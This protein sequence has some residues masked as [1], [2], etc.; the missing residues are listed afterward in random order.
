MDLQPLKYSKRV[1]DPLHGAIFLSELEFKITT[2]PAFIRLANVKQLGLAANVYPGALYSR[3]VHSLGACHVAGQMLTALERNSGSN[4]ESRD[5]TVVK[6]AALMHDIGHYPFS[7]AT[8]EVVKDLVPS[9]LIL[10][11]GGPGKKSE[12]GY[13][14][15]HED[16][17]RFIIEQ[18][19]AI[20]DVLKKFKLTPKEIIT[21]LDGGDESNS[22][23][24]LVSSDLDCDRLDY[25]R[26][27][28]LNAGLPY[29]GV[30]AQYLIDNITLDS[31]NIPCLRERAIGSADH[32]LVSRLYDF[33]QLPFHKSVVGFEE[34]L[35]ITLRSMMGAGALD[36][37]RSGIKEQISKGKWRRFDDQF[38]M[39]RIRQFRDDVAE[40]NKKYEEV[41]PFID[42]ILNR[43]AP[44][45]VF[46]SEFVQQ[47]SEKNDF[48]FERY[49]DSIASIVEA[50]C[51]E[52]G[53]EKHLTFSWKRTFPILKGKESG[54]RIRILFGEGALDESFSI[55]R[56][57]RTLCAHLED[58]AR[59][60][61]RFYACLNGNDNP[62]RK[63]ADL[64]GKIRERCLQEGVKEYNPCPES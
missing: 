28:A 40:S 9:S 12:G 41:I 27:T 26:R 24:L 11:E 32:F 46:S 16:L 56:D 53:V 19:E 4:L 51:L 55:E 35:K 49:F 60:H 1:N 48:E 52:E 61:I 54:Q 29:G 18:D 45:L 6:L 20:N 21:T 39:E 15:D 33:E 63:R 64:R 25:L 3:Y 2:T 57:S 30:D 34:A 31:N 17:G 13:F 8:E 62:K 14:K 43:R 44:K 22:L 36:L 37:S 7:H 59:R 42:S 38:V 58:Y 23:N 5:I 10:D 50:V 47:M